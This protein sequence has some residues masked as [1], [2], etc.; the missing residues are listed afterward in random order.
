[1]G[2]E[3]MDYVAVQRKKL[4]HLVRN[5]SLEPDVYTVRMLLLLRL[6][7]SDLQAATKWVGGGTVNAARDQATPA[8]IA[9]MTELLGI[10]ASLLVYTTHS[11]TLRHMYCRTTG[12]FKLAEQ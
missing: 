12:A 11:S 10:G 9:D 8:S 7:W 4:L 1:M 3:K 6:T 5:G 2:R